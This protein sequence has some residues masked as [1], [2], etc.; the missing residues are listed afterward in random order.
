MDFF[1]TSFER[2]RDIH[3]VQILNND[4]EPG[5]QWSYLKVGSCWN[6]PQNNLR[7]KNVKTSFLTT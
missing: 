7:S 6:R 1:C 2:I 5:I 4:K 3:V